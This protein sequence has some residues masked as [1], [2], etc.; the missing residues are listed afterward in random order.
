[1]QIHGTIFCINL[2]V[3]YYS[4]QN[5][6]F[7]YIY[8]AFL[9]RSSMVRNDTSGHQRTPADTSGHQRT[10]A[11]TSSHQRTP[12]A[13]RHG[14][15]RRAAGRGHRPGIYHRRT[16]SQGDASHVAR[17][18]VFIVNRAKILCFNS[19][20]SDCYSVLKGIQKKATGFR[21][22]AFIYFMYCPFYIRFLLVSLLKIKNL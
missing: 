16:G 5:E 2:T 9:W 12:A 7:I 11:D 15:P 18:G 6:R 13:T 22:I 1:M 14:G 10:P 21:P 4:N 3:I 17:R 19:K 8:R 20:L